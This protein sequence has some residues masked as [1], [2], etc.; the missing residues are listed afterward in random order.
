MAKE[1]HDETDKNDLDDI[2]QPDI[3]FE[4][5]HFVDKEIGQ[6][7]DS[8]VDDA[9]GDEHGGQELFGVFEQGDDAFPG[10]ILFGL[11]DIDILIGHGKKGHFRAGDH[12]GKDEK[13][14]NDYS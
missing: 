14:E 9:V 1:D 3:R 11:K 6:D 8:Y 2:E 12:K 4:Q 7:N 13:K 10:C 5:Y